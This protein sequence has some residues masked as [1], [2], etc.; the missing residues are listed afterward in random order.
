MFVQLV[1]RRQLAPL[2]QRIRLPLVPTLALALALELPLELELT[3]HPATSCWLRL[4]RRCV[5]GGG[6]R[7]VSS[8]AL[9][10]RSGTSRAPCGSCNSCSRQGHRHGVSARRLCRE[11]LARGLQCCTGSLRAYVPPP[12]SGCTCCVF[13][14]GLYLIADRHVEASFVSFRPMSPDGVCVLCRGVASVLYSY[15]VKC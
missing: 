13:F 12:R 7:M 9:C 5:S 15:F 8:R 1:P 11:D 6:S 4:W 3:R 10:P 2:L 14:C